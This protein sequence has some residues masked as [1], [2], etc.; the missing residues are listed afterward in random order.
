MR[1]GVSVI[2]LVVFMAFAST[3]FAIPVGDVGVEDTLVAWDTLSPSSEADEAQWVADY[4]GVDVSTITYTQLTDTESEGSNWMEV[5]GDS[6]DLWAFDF[7]SVNPDLFIVKTGNNI[8]LAGDGSSDTFTHYLYDNLISLRYGVINLNDFEA[9][10]GSITI[11]II[12]H[13]GTSGGTRVPEPATLL[14]L[15]SGLFGLGV[16][17]EKFKK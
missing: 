16:L 5:T 11:D 9:A 4:L 8:G 17:R 7:G 3:V 14:L 2:V 1:K 15:G 6:E 10:T 12:S 13:V